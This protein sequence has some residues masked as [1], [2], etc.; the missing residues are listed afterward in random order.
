MAQIKDAAR[1]KNWQPGLDTA[2]LLYAEGTVKGVILDDKDPVNPV[3][4]ILDK[5]DTNEVTAQF[6]TSTM[7]P[8]VN[9]WKMITYP[10]TDSV[11]VQW[12]MDFHLRWY[13]WE[14]F[15]SLLFEKSYGA[16]MEQG[17]TNLKKILQSSR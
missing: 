9:G 10:N 16:R 7:K 6:I 3:Y 4:I 5:T 14:K 12:Y 1:W 11:T 2:K 17:L 8:V 13:P 15:G